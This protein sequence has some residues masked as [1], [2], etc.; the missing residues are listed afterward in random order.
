MVKLSAGLLAF[1]RQEGGE[2]ELLLVHPGGP[3]WVHKEEGAWSIAKGEYEPYEEPSAA[4]D[5]EFR[6]EL[7]Q[8]P[9]DGERIDLGEIRQPS[10]KR[11]RIFA[12]E[13]GSICDGDVK[14]NHFE[15]EWPPKSGR[16]CSFPE[17]DRAEWTSVAVAR[18]RLSKGQ[19]PFVDR[20]I[21]HL[22]PSSH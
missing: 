22:G 14:S 5:R 13:G 12:A 4:A 10:G 16:I 2:L 9:P 17:V 21:E 18:N 1:R 15:L 19:V 7:G 8:D 6:E 11:L 3:F 20:L